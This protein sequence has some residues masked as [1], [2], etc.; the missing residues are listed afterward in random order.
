MLDDFSVIKKAFVWVYD[1]FAYLMAAVKSA[2]H[3]CRE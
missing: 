2:G 3:D 1:K